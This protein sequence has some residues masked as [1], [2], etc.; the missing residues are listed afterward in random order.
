VTD[1]GAA[2]CW[3][4]DNGKLGNGAPEGDQQSP[5][6]VDMSALPGVTWAD[7]SGGR[8]HTCGLTTD[9]VAYCWGNDASGELG[10]GAVT[11]VQESPS[12]VDVSGLPAGTRWARVDA[13]GNHTCAL[14]TAGAAYCWGGDFFGPSAT[15]PTTI[16]PCSGSMR[17]RRPDRTAAW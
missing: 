5:T 14:T 2:Y 7:V 10:N 16:M 3:G 4:G 9:G 15:S 13:A 1:L 8:E 6:P 11:G 17:A 12:P